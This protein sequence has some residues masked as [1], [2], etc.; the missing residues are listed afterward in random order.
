MNLSKT[1]KIIHTIFRSLLFLTFVMSIAAFCTLIAFSI[2]CDEYEYY[3]TYKIAQAAGTAS[4]VFYVFLALCII[5]AIL[6]LVCYKC[7][8]IGAT[9]ARSLFLIIIAATNIS[10]IKMYDLFNNYSSAR[11][12]YDYSDLYRYYGGYIDSDDIEVKVGFIIIFLLLAMA[13]LFVLSITSI[14]ALAKKPAPNYGYG[15]Q[16]PY[17]AP[18]MYNNNLNGAMGNGPQFGG[19]PQMNNGPQ[20]GGNPQM[21]NGP[22]FNGN[23]QM[24]NGPQ[25]NGN[26]QM[27]SAPQDTESQ[28]SESQVSESQVSESQ[29]MESQDTTSQNTAFQSTP[30]DANE[31]NNTQE[32]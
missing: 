22:Q 6:S 10:S 5:I 19:N 21:N 8:S 28:V 14:V 29:S 32:F 12:L 7:T 11:G 31:D 18:G 30:Q 3:N 24:N 17:G 13:V 23:P 9:V 25:F 27:D 1:Q 20:F 16:S 15:Q 4:K 2:A 26:P